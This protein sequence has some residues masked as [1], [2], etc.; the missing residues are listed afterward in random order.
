MPTSNRIF[1][2]PYA[3]ECIISEEGTTSDDEHK[4][5]CV[6]CRK[7]FQQ[8]SAVATRNGLA[9][10]KC[11]AK[12][13]V[14][15]D[16]CGGY[17]HRLSSLVKTTSGLTCVHCRQTKFFE[18]QRC[19]Q[20]V[21]RRNILTCPQSKQTFCNECGL[22]C[23]CD[24]HTY[25]ENRADPVWRPTA[26][27]RFVGDELGGF[28]SA[29]FVGVE[30]E[31]EG[32][33][34]YEAADNV[35]AACGI[36]YD[37]SLRGDEAIEVQT[38]PASGDALTRMLKETTSNMRGAG[39]RTSTRCGSHIHIDIEDLK[40]N[41]GLLADLFRTYYAVED[42]LYSTLP[43]SRWH[44]KYCLQ[45]RLNYHYTDFNTR[46]ISSLDKRWYKNGDDK[47]VY[48]LKQ[49][50]A[51]NP[52]RYTGVNFH[53]IFYRGTLELRHLNGTLSFTK[54][55]NWINFNMAIIGYASTRFDSGEM[56]SLLSR[57]MSPEKLTKF[58]QVFN[59]TSELFNYVNQKVREFNPQFKEFPVNPPPKQVKANETYTDEVREF[60]AYTRE[61]LRGRVGAITLEELESRRLTLVNY[62]YVETD[63]ETRQ[64]ARG[65]VR[66]L[67]TYITRLAAERIREREDE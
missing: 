27:D 18:C 60:I 25:G 32:G 54:L 9:C 51:A 13:F 36:A 34:R 40:G 23:H 59:L 61:I 5:R 7:L 50:R 37:G 39:Y 64:L 21:H 67:E 56:K 44:N 49:K 52:T 33:R 43:T 48:L 16:S 47:A 65:V 20:L 58:Y 46:D 38:P 2:E 11:L 10:P 6:S 8:S 31:A 28:L 26:K 55:Q 53:S 35:P 17:V 57:K 29:R 45:L 4:V 14:T 30:L 12:H 22:S 24:S 15:C 19:G 63:T 1:I 42:I 62:N 66:D 41:G 3:T